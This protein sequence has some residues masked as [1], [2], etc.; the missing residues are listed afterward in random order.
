M[1]T[2][3]G[4]LV[5]RKQTPWHLIEVRENQNLRWLHFGSNK[6]QSAMDKQYPTRLLLDYMPIMM[7]G[8]H[9]IPPPNEILLLGLGGGALVRYLLAKLPACHLT[10][11]ELN[12]D[13]ID[14]AYQ[15]FALPRHS[16]QLTIIAADAE[17]YLKQ[18]KQLFDLILVDIF[19]ADKLP[20]FCQDQRFYQNGRRILAPNGLLI[21]NLLCHQAKQLYQVVNQ[22]RL[23]FAKQTLYIQVPQ[24]TNHLVFAFNDT[25]YTQTINRLIDQNI[26]QRAQLDLNLGLCAQQIRPLD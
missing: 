2:Q 14:V 17:H 11:V 10:V 19:G 21:T 25:R 5:Y 12:P 24:Q 8:L 9:F 6:Y 26:I 20:A 23:A 4:K 7:A 15:Y 13:V 3:D 1:S 16:P 18:T 22:I